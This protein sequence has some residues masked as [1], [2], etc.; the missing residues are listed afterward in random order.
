MQQKHE[1]LLRH[2]QHSGESA[3]LVMALLHTAAL[4]DRACAQE[5][6]AFELSEGRLALLLAVANAEELATPALV[7]TQLG[8][9]RAAVTGLIDGLERQHLLERVANGTDRRSIVLH[10]TETGRSV[11]NQI[12]P[13]YG[14]WL[15]VLSAGV[16][17]DAVK[18]SLA[19]LT[20][21][22]RNI[23]NLEGGSAAN[24]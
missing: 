23:A 9:T 17:D 2:A 15:A 18:R 4:I 1:L 21:I 24:D 8:V 14:E 11:L 7:A 22:Q 19:A 6:A 5:L 10:L 12:G 13:R 20:A 3:K 16:D